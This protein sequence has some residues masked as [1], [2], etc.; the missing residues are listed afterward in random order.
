MT[1]SMDTGANDFLSVA[2]MILPSNDGFVGIDSWPI[3]AEA[4]TY[5]LF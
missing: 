2:A 5:T 3:P 1:M 4:G